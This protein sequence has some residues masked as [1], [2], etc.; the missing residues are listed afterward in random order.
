MSKHLSMFN[1]GSDWS[2]IQVVFFACF[3]FFLTSCGGSSSQSLNPGD[4][5]LD[6]STIDRSV[7][8]TDEETP[9]FDVDAGALQVSDSNVVVRLNGE[10]SLEGGLEPSAVLWQQISGPQVTIMNSEQLICD[11]VISDFTEPTQL[12]FQLTVW[13]E[14]DESNSAYTTIRV[15]P[16]DAFARVTGGE[17]NESDGTASFGIFLN[18]PSNETIYINYTTLDGTAIANEDYI[19]VSGEL[20]FSPGETEKT[21]TV[22]LIDDSEIE[23]AEDFQLQI[24]SNLE[25]GEFAISGAV[26][27]ANEQ[28][29][30]LDQTIQFLAGD[31]ATMEVGTTLD[32]QLDTTQAPGTGRLLVSSSDPTVATI[33]ETGL[34]SALA[35]G[36]T[37]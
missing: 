29:P 30:Q 21:V 7:D 17:V 2:K 11:V 14:N 22:T 13:N 5:F 20:V 31:S 24:S 1:S 19:P 25:D 9:V 32:S 23:P 12:D 15:Q 34:I 10:A 3:L 18:A 27:I 6:G 36:S 26:I 37:P 28:D 8:N 16:Q 35:V 33:D 4:E